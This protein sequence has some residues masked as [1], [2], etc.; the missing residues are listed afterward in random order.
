MDLAPSGWV[1][2]K[3][4]DAHRVRTAAVLA[5]SAW[6]GRHRLL[7]LVLEELPSS[8]LVHTEFYLVGG[9]IEPESRD[10]KVLEAD[11][12]RRVA[13]ADISRVYRLTLVS[14]STLLLVKGP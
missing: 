8:L 2:L 6:Q 4:D 9:W 1:A 13:P 11:L 5:L 12:L 7:Q 14:S 10:Q 3:E